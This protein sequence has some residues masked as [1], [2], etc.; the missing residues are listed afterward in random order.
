VKTLPLA[1]S[2]ITAI[3]L[4][5]GCASMP[6]TLPQEQISLADAGEIISGMEEQGEGVRSFYAVGTVS[7]K[8]KILESDAEILAAGVKDP[9]TMKI[10]ITH[11][12]GS[13]LLHVLIKD[14]RLE[15]LSFQ[16]KVLYAGAFTPEA[17]SRFLSG[18]SLDEGMIWSI[19]S[20]RPPIAVHEALLPGPGR[21]IL[22]G[23]EGI[24]LETVF[25]PVKA[26]LPARV[27][28]PQQSMEVSF[29]DFKEEG[30]I[31]YAGEIE[32]TGKKL[33]GD[34]SL[35]INRISLNAS[36]PDQIFNL[37][38]P[39]TYETVDLDALN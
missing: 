1:I 2:V 4:S 36:V 34:L 38:R 18:F 19:L 32:L 7:V 8:G 24:E 3:L 23:S 27:S 20:G 17:L 33:R 21:I 12:W 22:T 28:F 37:E 15:V 30:G 29:S 39:S 16:D 5:G 35:K 9:F 11:S 14:G 25:L 13:P 26:H 6:G 10:E 31:S